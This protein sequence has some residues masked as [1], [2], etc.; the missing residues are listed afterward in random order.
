M[1]KLFTMFAAV[2]A[3]AFLSSCSDDDSGTGAEGDLTIS[4][5]PT[6]AELVV[7]ATL[8]VSDIS[9]A[10]EDGIAS[11]TLSVNG[12]SAVDLLAD[13]DFTSG[14]ESYT[15]ASISLEKLGSSS[16]WYLICLLK[17]IIL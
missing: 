17:S 9:I 11:F 8:T 5:I 12:G 13:T 6:T 3:V 10:A 15:I 14:A 7:G 1:R 4:G 2:A 16:S